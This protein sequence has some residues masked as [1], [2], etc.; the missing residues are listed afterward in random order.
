MYAFAFIWECFDFP[1]I[2]EICFCYLSDL[3]LTI[4]FPHWKMCHFL[5]ASV[6]SD[7]KFTVIWILFLYDMSF[8][9]NFK[10]LFF[11]LF[12][13]NLLL[14]SLEFSC[15]GIGLC[16]LLNLWICV[17]HEIWESLWFPCIHFTSTPFSSF[18][19]G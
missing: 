19:L 8:F 1:F 12:S 10:I 17:F 16:T 7:G 14:I 11:I 15:L 9:L 2:P 5:L 3:M 13:W 18:F 4:L 6:V